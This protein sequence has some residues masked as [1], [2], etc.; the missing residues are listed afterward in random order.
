MDKPKLASEKRPGQSEGVDAI[1]RHADL[2]LS[3]TDFLRTLFRLLDQRQVRYCVLHSWEGLPDELASDLDLAVH[4]EDR[5]K[6]S[7]V[8]R[9]LLERGYRPIQCRRYSARSWRFDFVWFEPDGMRSVDLDF[10][11]GFRDKGL[12][13]IS[14]EELVGKR[15]QFNGFWV[16]DPAIEF[17]YLL[18]KKTLKGALP[19]HQA[20]CLKV[21]V[22]ELGKP[23]AQRIAGELFGEG[24]KERVVEAS[25]SGSLGGLL[26]GLRKRL[27]WTKLRKDPLNPLRYFWSDLS[28]LIARW[29]KPTGLFL[30]ILGPD[31]VG[32]STLIGRL[33]GSLTAAAFAR[34]RI[35]HWRPMV[36]A[37]QKETGRVVTDPHEK[38]ARGTLASVAA[39]LV[40]FLDYWLGYLLVLQPFMARSGLIVFDRCFQDLLVDPL[41]YR[42]GGP[43]WFARLLNRFVPLPDLIFLVLDAEEKV[44]FSRKQEV[45]P[46]ELRR[47]RASY[48]QLT[49]NRRAT[50]IKADRG[51]EMTYEE[52]CRFIIENMVE[53]F[54]HQHAGWLALSQ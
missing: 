40:V 31:G 14:G 18:A 28:R 23:R 13:L 50:L 48:R 37:R 15:R 2:G 29:F 3:Q 16:A 33:T 30:V 27:W 6:L 7:W 41:R 32:K 8:F 21:L 49:V 47:Q 53:R 54:Q 22:N 36:I 11:E 19:P 26:Q 12:I 9:T 38:P 51:A 4:P 1:E 42:Y 20:E 44:I 25:S 17:A 5:A 35:F 46:E 24:W 45:S 43:A 52:A 10:T 34:C 39:L